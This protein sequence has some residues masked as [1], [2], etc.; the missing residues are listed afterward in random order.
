MYLLFKFVCVSF[1]NGLLFIN[2]KKIV[3]LTP[4][5]ST[6]DDKP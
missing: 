4:W 1:S 6:K 5:Y 3:K 2:L